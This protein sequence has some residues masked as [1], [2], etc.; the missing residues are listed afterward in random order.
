MKLSSM[1]PSEGKFN[2]MYNKLKKGNVF[3][4]DMSSKEYSVGFL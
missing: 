3:P 1:W 2:C 4:L